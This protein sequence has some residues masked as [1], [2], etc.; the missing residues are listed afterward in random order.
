MVDHINHPAIIAREVLPVVFATAS[1]RLKV[2]I[3]EHNPDVV[4]SLGQAEGRAEISIERIAINVDDARIPDNAGNSPVNRTIIPGAPAAYFSTLPIERLVQNL[5]QSNLK[6]SISNSA[7]TFV[8]NHIFYVMQHHLVEKEVISG[9]IHLPLMHEQSADFP[10]QPTME[11]R[12][13]I[14]GVTIVLDLVAN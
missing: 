11:L 2:L 9:F 13:M 12:E 14:R 10:N 7:G 6:A 3:D 8:C 1:A 5:Q 4:I